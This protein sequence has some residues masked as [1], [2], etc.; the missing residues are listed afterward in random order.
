MA[1]A[2]TGSKGRGND[3]ANLPPNRGNPCFWHQ[4]INLSD[5]SKSEDINSDAI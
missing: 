4:N 3:N 1:M 2:P 5:S